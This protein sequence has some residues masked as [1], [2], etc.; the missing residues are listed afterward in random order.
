[1]PP[2]LLR[3]VPR[4]LRPRRSRYTT[5]ISEIRGRHVDHQSSHSSGKFIHKQILKTR[6]SHNQSVFTAGAEGHE[7]STPS[8]L[9]VRAT[10]AATSRSGRGSWL[11]RDSASLIAIAALTDPRA[12]QSRVDVSELVAKAVRRDPS[13]LPM[14]DPPLQTPLHYR[15]RIL[16][17]SCHIIDE[18]YLEGRAEAEEDL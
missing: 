16:N 11:Q 2:T 15:E 12:V 3:E 14:L 8:F 18:S 6:A 17:S 13:D 5:L 1:V 9:T 7:S 4:R 10:R